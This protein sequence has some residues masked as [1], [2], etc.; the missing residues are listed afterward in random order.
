M[1]EGLVVEFICRLE[2]LLRTEKCA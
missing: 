2:C 1:K